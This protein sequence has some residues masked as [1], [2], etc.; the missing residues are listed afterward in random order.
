MVKWF[1]PQMNTNEKH[2]WTWVKSDKH[3]LFRIYS[4][5]DQNIILCRLALA[6]G[7]AVSR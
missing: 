5:V 7:H 1:Y 6:D 3:R 2:K 4:L